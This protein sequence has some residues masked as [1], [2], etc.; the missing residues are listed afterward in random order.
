MRANLIGFLV[1]V[2][3]VSVTSVVQASDTSATLQPRPGGWLVNSASDIDLP[4][5]P[6]SDESEINKVRELVRQRSAADVDR[7]HWWDAGGPAYRWNEIAIETMLEE[8]VTSLPASRNLG[9]LHAAIDDAVMAASAAQ[10]EVKRLRPSVVDPSIEAALPVPES[11][12][13]PSENAA[14]AAAAAGV[15]GYLFPDRKEM[16]ADRA[17]EAMRSRLLAGLEYPSDVDAGRV[18]GRKMADLA[19]ARGKSDGS[20]R[21]WTGTVP[22][23]RDKWQGSDPIAPMA[24]TWQPWVLSRPDEFRPAAPPDIDS[25]EVRRSLAELKTFKRT[26]ESKHRAAY[27]DVFGGARGY[28]LWNELA[29]MKLLEYGGIFDPRTSARVLA[30]VNIAYLDATIACFDAKYTYWYIRPSQLD[31]T[32]ETLFPT[33]NH[34]SYPAGNSCVSTAAATV[35]AEVFPR[36]SKRFLALAKEAGE[37]RIWAGI[38]Y[39]FDIE[40]GETVG[41]QVA[42]KVLAR[43]FTDGEE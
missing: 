8:F 32:L 28:S 16:F 6:A 27:W 43:A 9:L 3:S 17:E 15:L 21:K 34:P 38:H 18:I 35:L 20:D 4:P 23:G 11:P 5:P 31:P 12:S 10:Q 40:A 33:P 14:A 30:A 22:Q 24:G 7:I 25:A 26:P 2:A 39:R 29:R 19:I 13:F 37:S 41:R 1:V 42:E 36:D